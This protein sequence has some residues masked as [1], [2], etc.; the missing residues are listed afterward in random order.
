MSTA[1]FETDKIKAMHGIEGKRYGV[2]TLHRPSNV[3]SAE[4]MTRICGALKEIAV[5]FHW[6]F[7]RIRA[8]ESIFRDSASIWDLILS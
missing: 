6:Y 8:L 4:M 7:P 2:V 1:A 3:D 5:E